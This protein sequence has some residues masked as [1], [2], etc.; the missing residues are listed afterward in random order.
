MANTVKNVF[1]V[2]NFIIFIGILIGAYFIYQN[3]Q[4][5]GGKTSEL[6]RLQNLYSAGQFQD[7]LNEYEKLSAK[8]PEIK[9]Q[10]NEQLSKCYAGL[11]QAKYEKALSLPAN[12]RSSP[13]SEVSSLLEKA[14]SLSKLD[15]EALQIYCDAL[16]DSGNFDKASQ[17]I[18]D[19]ESRT[20]IDAKILS[21]YKMRIEKRK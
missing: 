21:I 8:Y 2:I 20:D 18:R 11:A 15:I 7:F 5:E 19:A 13:M 10:H 16:L 9:G 14:E 17:V 1:R 12:E 4:K 3:I 6:N